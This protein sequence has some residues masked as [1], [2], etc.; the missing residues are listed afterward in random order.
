MITPKFIDDAKTALRNHWGETGEKIIELCSKE[1]PFEGN[2]RCFS[3]ECIACGGNL[4]GMMLSGIKR[5]YPI[6]W[7]TIPD[8]M[9]R[10]GIAFECVASTL[11]L[12]GVDCS[13]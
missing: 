2:F 5:L 11:I 12:L 3:N 7:A 1:K 13:E 8:N 10:G 4:V 9:G 6:V